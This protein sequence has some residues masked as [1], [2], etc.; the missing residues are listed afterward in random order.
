MSTTTATLHPTAEI[1]AAKDADAKEMIRHNMAVSRAWLLRAVVAIWQRQT[2]DEKA[3]NDTT[4]ENG[5]GFNH[6]DAKAMSRLA[7]FIKNGNDIYPDEIADARRRM[8]K[9]AG[10]LLEIARAKAS[11][12]EGVAS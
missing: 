12:Q 7:L 10:Q 5:V 4:H 11:K 1:V 3:R 2:A 8:R 6:A 9:Y